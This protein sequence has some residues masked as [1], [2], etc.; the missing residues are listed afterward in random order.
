MT[1]IN[2][3]SVAGAGDTPRAVAMVRNW[4]V[5]TDHKQLGRMFIVLATLFAAGAAVAGVLLGI[6]GAT[7]TDVLKGSIE[8]VVTSYRTGLTFVVVLPLM[9]GLA[10][11]VVPLQVGARA[12]A[13][14]RLAA[15][16]FWTWLAGAVLLGVAV[17]SNGGPGGGDR[18]MVRMFLTAHILL[19]AGLLAVAVSLATTIMTTRTAGMNMRRV[20]PFTWS[21]LVFSVCLVLALPVLMGAMLLNYV[22]YRYG[23]GW[24]GTQDV[25]R[26]TG[27]GSSQP[28]TFVYA[29]PVFGFALE[30]VATASRRRLPMRGIAWA[31]VGLVGVTALGGITQNR[32]TLRADFADASLND[33]IADAVPFL[34]VNLLPVLGALVVLG[35][36]GLA[37]KPSRP[38]ISAP[39]LFGFFAAAMVF[40]GLLANV[41][42]QVADLE[43]DT[44]RFAGVDFA[45]VNLFEEGVWLYVMYGAVLMAIGAVAYWS[46]KLWGAV[47]PTKLAAPLVLLGLG[48]V[49][50]SSLPLLIAG[51]ADDFAEAASAISAAGHAL[52]ALTVL[53]FAALA[54]RTF[55]S[56]PVA[57]DDPWDGQTLE[58]TTASPAPV[59]NFGHVPTVISAEPLLDRKPTIGSDA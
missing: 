13:F 24:G 23:D 54:A 22:A 29:L 12:L 20:P 44:S 14:G 32:A 48:G 58:W 46:P 43:L 34:F 51:F 37:L 4:F 2:A 55:V 18:Q 56:G 49:V 25:I 28:M 30:T 38:A 17:A 10:T 9:I 57:A 8:Q 59:D 15:T 39:L 45:G 47:L 11:A 19:L 5:S 26:W 1:T 52:M 53:A 31:G 50:V 40:V 16:G 35:V 21:V 3:Q 6:D 42:A 27:F 36:I 7:D 33:Q 41:L